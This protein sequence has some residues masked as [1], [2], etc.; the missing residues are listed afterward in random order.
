MP[1]EGFASSKRIP[2]FF[3]PLEPVITFLEQLF[4]ALGD[5]RLRVSGPD[6]LTSS[7]N[8]VLRRVLGSTATYGRTQALPTYRLS[9]L[10]RHLDS[11]R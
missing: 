8:V 5:V 7:R 1:I 6:L 4:V 3:G 10:T 11:F 9:E 2:I